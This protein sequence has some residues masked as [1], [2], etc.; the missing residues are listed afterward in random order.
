[1]VLMTRDCTAVLV[2]DLGS[3]VVWLVPYCATE[4]L[5]LEGCAV[6]QALPPG[7]GPRHVALHPAL[8][9]LYVLNE[10]SCT[11]VACATDATGRPLPG[12]APFAATTRVDADRLCIFGPCWYVSIHLRVSRYHKPS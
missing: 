4:G 11:L 5:A 2:P 6:A 3:D 10:L 9:V 7:S 12:A 8:P 1:M